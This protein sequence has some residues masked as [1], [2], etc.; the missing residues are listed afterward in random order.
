MES[1]EIGLQSDGLEL[2][3]CLGTGVI[4]AIFLAAGSFPSLKEQFCNNWCSA[5]WKQ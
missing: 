3:P 1:S 2:L 4:L 5:A